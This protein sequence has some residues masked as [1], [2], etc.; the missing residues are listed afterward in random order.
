MKRGVLVCSLLTQR[1]LDQSGGNL[2]GWLRACARFSLQ[3]NF[4]GS[5]DV[6]RGQVGEPQVPLLIHGDDIEAPNWACRDY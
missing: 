2:V 6:Y 3:R 5:I 1:W 4:F